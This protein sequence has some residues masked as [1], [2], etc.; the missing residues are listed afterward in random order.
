MPKN[1]KEQVSLV[2]RWE[3]ED[4][5]PIIVKKKEKENKH[6]RRTNMLDKKM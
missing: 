2:E 1:K 3:T 6:A 5:F 4:D